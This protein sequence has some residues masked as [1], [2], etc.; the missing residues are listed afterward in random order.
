MGKWCETTKRY[1][2]D[3]DLLRQELEKENPDKKEIGSIIFK[4]ETDHEELEGEVEELEYEMGDLKREI[5]GLEDEVDW[6]QRKDQPTSS[7]SIIDH[8]FKKE[9]FSK[10]SEKYQ[11]WELEEKLKDLL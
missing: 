2:S 11:W 7:P 5:S 8:H 4:I 9:I 1:L 6:Y 3:F 10:L